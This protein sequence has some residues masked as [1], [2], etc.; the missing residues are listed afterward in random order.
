M[1]KL[2]AGKRAK[3]PRGDFAGPGRSFPVNDPNHARLAKSAA[4]RKV[5]SGTMS[6][7][8]EASID[9]KANKVLHGGKTSP[10]KTDRGTFHMKEN[11]SNAAKPKGR[12]APIFG[13]KGG[14]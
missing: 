1:A 8:E 12:A 14:F 11:R 10:V 7:G 4:S 3:L 6:K 9:A 5:N 13:G 2:T